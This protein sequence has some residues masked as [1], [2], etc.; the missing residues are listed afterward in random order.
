ML[1][2]C[3]SSERPFVISPFMKNG[4]VIQ[5]IRR[6]PGVA[7]LPILQDVAKG[8]L[9]LHHRNV[10]HGDI[11]GVNILIDDAGHA[12][13]TDF[14]FA[15]LD[16]TLVSRGSSSIQNRGAVGTG[17]TLRWMAPELLQG[18]EPSKAGDIYAFGIT[19]FEVMS[20]GELP[21]ANLS[22][23]LIY[24]Q[25]IY[26]KRRPTRPAVCADEMWS[27]MQIAWSEDPSDRKPFDFI[28]R[29]I[30]LMIIKQTQP[31]QPQQLSPANT[32]FD[33]SYN[34][35]FSQASSGPVL[36]SMHF[37]STAGGSDVGIYTPTMPSMP[38]TAPSTPAP[39]YQSVDPRVRATL[40]PEPDAPY[41]MSQGS[42]LAGARKVGSIDTSVGRTSH[43]NGAGPSGSVISSPP[44][45]TMS[46]PPA[47]AIPTNVG[48]IGREIVPSV[49][50]PSISTATSSNADDYESAMQRVLGLESDLINKFVVTLIQ[51]NTQILEAEQQ[52]Y[53]KH[54]RAAVELH[55]AAL[56][57]SERLM[58]IDKSPQSQALRTRALENKSQ[59]FSKNRDLFASANMTKQQRDQA[60]RGECNV[61]ADRIRA[62]FHQMH[63]ENRRRIQRD[64]VVLDEAFIAQQEMHVEAV[65][66]KFMSEVETRHAAALERL[67]ERRKALE[68]E[69]EEIRVFGQTIQ[70]ALVEATQKVERAAQA[71]SPKKMFGKLFGRKK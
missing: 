60:I 2:V 35:S 50:A 1:G 5:Y 33:H 55:D 7:T 58:D 38:S 9:Y 66:A 57:Y 70:A 30:G 21:Y 17:G 19:M 20:K 26:E 71:S 43:H 29:M 48:Y 59:G 4:N 24:P 64:E 53:I 32:S 22:D 39:P 45:H 15:K 63:R 65:Y 42:S 40:S 28:E 52:L 3:L 13:V 49:Y 16:K 67:E 44:T 11:K 34:S 61:I 8:M 31:H 36:P 27:L 41:A 6:Y 62:K 51:K 23:Q 37:R 69:R 68:S 18:Q 10:V 46:P 12:L 14:G 47:A 25:V 54:M 56:N